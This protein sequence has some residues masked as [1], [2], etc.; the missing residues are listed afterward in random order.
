MKTLFEV[1]MSWAV[2]L[3]GY[4]TPAAIPEVVAVPPARIAAEVC[5]GARC[6]A[7]AWLD[8]HADRIYV[9]ERIDLERD[10]QAQSYLVHEFVHHLQRQAGKLR[11]GLDCAGRL[12]LDREAYGV[13]LRFL[14]ESGEGGGAPAA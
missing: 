14:T 10:T 2:V 1:L 13:Q 5:G 11:A 7:V 9:D 12:A 3:S 4:P 6:A 8:P